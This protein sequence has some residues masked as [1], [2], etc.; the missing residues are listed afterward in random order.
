M[1]WVK[2]NTLVAAIALVLFLAPAG[3]AQYKDVVR[4]ATQNLP[5]YH[6]IKDGKI[7]GIAMRRVSCA[8]DIMD[9]D[10]EIHMMDWKKAQLMTQNNEMSGFFVGSPNGS[11]AKYATPSDPVITESLTWFMSKGSDI[12][13]SDPD[14]KLSARYG[15]KFATSK[16][17]NLKKKKFNVHKKPRDA[18]ALLKM[19]ANGEIDVALEYE[20]IFEHYMKEQKISQDR[21]E[22]KQYKNQ[23]NMVHFSKSFLAARPQFLPQFNVNLHSCK[24]KEK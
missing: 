12:D 22:K 1:K 16:W 7:V 8:L 18:L 15:A 23:S 24:V 9:V 21:F 3:Q 4:L 11:R 17:Y 13:P 6:M 19:L 14:Y 5:P 20:M 10:Y 2:I